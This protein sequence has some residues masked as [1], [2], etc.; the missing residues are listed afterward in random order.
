MTNR[1]LDPHEPRR[2][3]L[4]DAAGKERDATS[5]WLTQR[6]DCVSTVATTAEANRMTAAQR[7]DIVVLALEDPAPE[8]LTLIT[9]LRS[10]NASL[11][12]LAICRDASIAA[13]SDAIHTDKCDFLVK[14]IALDDLESAIR[15]ISRTDA[16]PNGNKRQTPKPRIRRS[17][18]PIIGK[19]VAIEVVHQWIDRVAPC[20]MPVLIEGESGTGKELVA[21]EIHAASRVADRPMITINCAAVPATL[22]ESELFGHEKGS[23][24]GA[25]A[26]KRGLFEMADGGTL[27]V[28]ELGELAGDLQAK[29]LRVLEDGRIRRVGSTCERQ[30]HVRLLAATNKRLADEVRAGRFREDL[31]YRINVLGT[32]LPALRERS[33]DIGLLVAHFLGPGWTLGVGVL[34]VLERYTWPGNVRQL[35][36]AIERSKVLSAEPGIV[37]VD[38][39]PPEIVAASGDQRVEIGG[40]ID[41]ETINRSHVLKVLQQHRGNKAK[42]ARV[43][44]INRRSLYRL[45]DKYGAN[46]R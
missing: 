6:G 11:P 21:S 32:R 23:F 3:L 7:F 24:T 46:Q 43:L 20:E 44:G 2:V 12:I 10:Q 30:V 5:H 15:K 9:Q 19:S 34:P 28:D 8:A 40:D 1:T 38:D 27:F 13:A 36:N 31:F 4:V 18:S 29:L 35:S 16:V 39:L 41:L 26:T 33:D 17:V 22:L 37:S 45:L 42:T 25:I 14:P